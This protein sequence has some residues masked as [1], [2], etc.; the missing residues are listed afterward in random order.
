VAPL[1]H[2]VVVVAVILALSV[3]GSHRQHLIGSSR[4]RVAQY[5][6]TLCWE[7]ALL[8]FCLWG[9]RKAGVGIRQLV[10][11]R[12]HEI[13]DVLI[14]VLIA[15]GFWLAA[16]ITLSLAAWALG[17]GGGNHLDEARRQLGFLVPRGTAEV[18]LWIALSITAGV[19]EETIFRGYL[20]R[21]FSALG[22]NAWIGIAG[23]ALIFGA[24]HG[25]E[26]A[27][28]MLLIG[29]YGAMFGLLADFRR[30]LRPGMMAHAFHDALMGL[31][32][33]FFLK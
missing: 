27:R 19:C 25:Y 24:A 13:E 11:G 18:L 2:T 21:Q 31:L 15:F 5:V 7:W 33:R 3:A 8:F 6:F 14:D 22:G 23:S 30:S 16:M 28:R 32:L 29:I 1:W 20:Q 4:A 26:G 17:L 10:G 9:T 12:W